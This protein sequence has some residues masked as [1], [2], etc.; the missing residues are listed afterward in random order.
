M[1]QK[2][3]RDDG[4]FA[5]F[6]ATGSSAAGPITLITNSAS[7]ATTL[8]TLF[9]D[10][11]TVAQGTTGLWFASGQI[12]LMSTSANTIMGRLWDGTSVIASGVVTVAGVNFRAT[13]P[14]SGFIL[15]PVGNIRISARFLTGAGNT[16]I[17]ATDAG[18][19]DDTGVDSTIT[20][21]RIG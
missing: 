4:V 12:T 2:F 16:S 5:A 10:G 7:T 1:T 6:A 17:L 3:L 15:N 9:K 20:A 21:I 19:V 18:F 14:L 13:L 11:P 8:T